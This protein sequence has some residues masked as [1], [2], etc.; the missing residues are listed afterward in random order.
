MGRRTRMRENQRRTSIRNRMVTIFVIVTSTLLLGYI[1]IYP[2]IKPIGEIEIPEFHDYPLV[3]GR[4]MGDPN[5]PVTIEVFEDFQCPG[6]VGYTFGA[7]LQIAD[8]YVASG[9]V[10]YIFQHYPFLDDNAPGDES[11]QSAI[12]SMC[13]ADQ[14]RFWEYHSIL[15][16]NWNGQN[17]GALN[18]R[19]LVAFAET[20]GLDMTE[21]NSCFNSR[22]HYD[23]IMQDFQRGKIMGVRGTPSVFI[24]G[25]II[26]PGYVPTF[27]AIREIVDPLLAEGDSP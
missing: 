17:E 10:Y 24:N 14:G 20:L 21:F 18:N 6:C 16:A 9:D 12:A 27:E 13:A 1:F 25:E 3:E 4:A 7:E 26:M 11:D 2:S 5:A 22:M 23:E 15:Y 19:R 8:T